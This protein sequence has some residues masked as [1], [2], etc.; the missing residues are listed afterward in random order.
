MSTPPAVLLQEAYDD[1]TLRYGVEGI[2]LKF[3]PSKLDVTSI[4]HMRREG[5]GSDVFETVLTDPVP[6]PDLVSNL[7]HPKISLFIDRIF[8]VVAP[9]SLCQCLIV[10]TLESVVDLYVQICHVQVQGKSEHTYWTVLNE[11]IILSNRQLKPQNACCDFE[12]ALIDDV[13]DQFPSAN[14]V[15]CLFH[16]K[17]ELRPKMIELR[18]PEDQVTDALSP[19]KLDT[20]TVIP[21]DDIAK[22]KST[23]ATLRRE[24]AHTPAYIRLSKAPNKNQPASP[25]SLDIKHGCQTAPQRTPPVE[26]PIPA[27]YGDAPGGMKRAASK[28]PP[29]HDYRG[30]F[31]DSDSEEGAVDDP[32]K[33]SNDLEEEQ[34]QYSSAGSAAR[35]GQATVS[36]TATVCP[37]SSGGATRPKGYYPSEDGTDAI[38]L[39]KKL[40]PPR[41]LVSGYTSRGAYERALVET[42]TLLVGDI[43]AARCVL[44]TRHKVPLDKFTNLRKKAEDKSGLQPV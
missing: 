6:H 11:L 37:L 17:Q 43:E 21:E 42:E 14:L 36:A 4:K 13:L 23:T 35:A 39:L 9:K 40:T 26:P 10:V 34:A 8:F 29:R 30:L 32:C 31:D 16:W 19:G 24:W 44:L 25:D 15:G 33:V 1:L 12:A 3:I 28:A 2:A 22:E 20:L 38:Q 7:R 41:G 18:L 5:S 27:D